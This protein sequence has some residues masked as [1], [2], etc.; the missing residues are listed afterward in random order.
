V[1][2]LPKIIKAVSAPELRQGLSKHLEETRNQ[3]ARL[4]K[5]G[6]LL[7]KKLTGKTCAGMKGIF[8]APA[9]LAKTE[10][11]PARD[12]ALISACQRLED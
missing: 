2:S 4:E 7:G 1:L 3:V 9:M 10:K 8:E 6:K 11:G 12:A 5:I